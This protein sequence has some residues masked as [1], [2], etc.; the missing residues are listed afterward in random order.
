MPREQKDEEYGYQKLAGFFTLFLLLSVVGGL[1][2]LV[3][4]LP[5]RL[6][7]G[8]VVLGVAWFVVLIV[9]VVQ[10]GKVSTGYKCPQCG[11]PLPQLPAE[12]AT[13]YEHRFLCK[14]CDVLWVT[15]V[16]EGDG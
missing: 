13:D 2:L 3:A 7:A 11:T 1:F 6:G 9:G 15:G 14:Q 4:G 12:K 10:M 16:H 5:P 8:S